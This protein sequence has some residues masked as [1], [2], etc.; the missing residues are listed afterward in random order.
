MLK[1]M[2]PPVLQVA[3][4]S[5]PI[6]WVS[7]AIVVTVA[8]YVGVA[9][10]AEWSV[11]SGIVAAFPGVLWL[12]LL[13]LSTLS[14]VLRF[15]R[16]H[17]FL[18]VLQHAVPVLRSLEIYLAAF[19]LTLTPGKAGETIRSTY[20]H[21]YGVGY[22]HS[23]GAFFSERL[24]DLLAVGGLAS[25]ALSAL[26]AQKPW[27]VTVAACV[28]CVLLLAWL[29]PEGVIGKLVEGRG[30]LKGA[31]RSVTTIRFLLSG[32]RLGLA[33]PLSVLAWLAQGVALYLIVDTLGYTLPVGRLVS[34]Y[35]LAMLAG[36]A[37]FIPGGVGATEAVIILLL[38][39]E[40]LERS[41]AITASLVSRSL[42]LWF[43]VAV[44]V[45]AM[46]RVGFALKAKPVGCSEEVSE[47]DLKYKI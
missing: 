5:A 18:S 39:A 40:G 9:N 34:I 30:L 2:R 11:F 46:T 23:V 15:A 47:A 26:P 6:R 22:P 36:A 41:H 43:A 27:A 42:T 7:L 16:W 10:L 17:Y 25:F 14:Y 19:A 1:K 4:R 8:L 21:S 28:L 13:G 37:S 33:I 3:A 38:S 20:L 31:G 35:C 44:G 29:W 32:R 24:L 45:L 12:Q